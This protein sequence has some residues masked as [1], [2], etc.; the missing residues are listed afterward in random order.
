M[1][2]TV[3]APAVPQTTRTL[4]YTLSTTATT[5]RQVE[6]VFF[7]VA[8]PVAMFLLFNGLFGAQ[9]FGQVNVGMMI[10]VR[11]AAYG[12]LGAAMNAGAL[13]QVERAN[14]WLR[15]LMVA[16]LMPRSFVVGKLVASLVVVL[17]AL[18]GVFLAG[19]L[20]TDVDV[21][22]LQA[23][24]AIGMLWICMIPMVLLGL[25]IGLALPQSA[26]GPVTTIGMMLLAMAGGLMVPYELFPTWLQHVADFL[27]SYW[28]GEMGAW[29]I[30]GGDLPLRGLLT[31]VVWT[32]ALA[33]I[34][35]LLVRVAARNSTRR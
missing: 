29:V 31:L 3:T 18:I 8:L 24:G 17:P 13:I 32:A 34:C 35:A 30:Y 9:S 26:V 4:R 19:A 16:G 28:I 10:M 12:G 21:H 23:L 15:Q 11:M 1:T 33:G 25:A 6:F 2:A 14:G 7:T 20:F 27:P 22:V 5:L